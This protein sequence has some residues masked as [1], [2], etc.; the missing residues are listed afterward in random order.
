MGLFGFVAVD[1][2]VP[3]CHKWPLGDKTALWQ[4]LLAP[5]STV[6]S[7]LKK[8]WEEETFSQPLNLLTHLR[9][10]PREAVISRTG[11]QLMLDGVFVLRLGVGEWGG[12]WRLKAPPSRTASRKGRSFRNV[13]GKVA[14]RRRES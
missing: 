12:R 7:S 8:K 1:Q 10:N 14:A 2:L 3:Q 9:L 5:I 6:E 13:S 4:R 11:G